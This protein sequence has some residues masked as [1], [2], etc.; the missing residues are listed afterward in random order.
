LSYLFIYNWRRDH[1]GEPIIDGSP[2]YI[3]WSASK[4]PQLLKYHF[5]QEAYCMSDNIHFSMKDVGNHQCPI[6]QFD[7]PPEID[8]H[9]WSVEQAIFLIKDRAAN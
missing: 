3:N 1:L 7:T 9:L 8:F 2:A 5:D 6:H 4:Y